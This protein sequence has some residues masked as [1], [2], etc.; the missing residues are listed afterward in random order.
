MK[1]LIRMSSIAGWLIG[2]SLLVAVALGFRVDRLAD[3][4]PVDNAM[5][6][7][8]DG[9]GPPRLSEAEARALVTQKAVAELAGTLGSAHSRVDDEGKEFVLP[10]TEIDGHAIALTDL[11]LAEFRFVPGAKSVKTSIGTGAA[12]G[13]SRSVWVAAW[14]RKGV[15]IEGWADP[16]DVEVTVVIEDRTG[17]VLATSAGATN[18]I[19]LQ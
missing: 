16:A 17:R 8:G 3:I 9:A 5:A 19:V 13:T 15:A 7:V 18:P 6:L 2:P 12:F 10:A 11:T 14:Q 4:I 1:R